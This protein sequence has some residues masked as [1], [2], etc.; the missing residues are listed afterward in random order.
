MGIFSFNAS[1][2]TASRRGEAGFSLVELM[3]VITIIGILAGVAVPRF[4]TFRA[5]SQQAEAKA[6]L[7]GLYLS[8]EAYQTN[9]QEYPATNAAAGGTAAPTVGVGDNYAASIGG[10]G[11][12]VAGN[13]PRYNYAVD[14][15]NDRWAGMARTTTALVDGRFDYQRVNAKKWV[16][17]AHDAVTGNTVTDSAAIS[18]AQS[19]NP[20]TDCPQGFTAAVAQGAAQAVVSESPA[21]CPAGIPGC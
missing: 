5:R 14:T 9:F 4:Q 21:D 11:F 13:N 16:C 18:A 10:I 12:A 6:G 8:M 2:R 19:A 3:V 17:S 15:E 1:A 20:Q 7:S